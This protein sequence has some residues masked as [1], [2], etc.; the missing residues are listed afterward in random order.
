MVKRTPP[1]TGSGVKPHRPPDADPLVGRCFV[2]FGANGKIRH[3]GIIRARVE[4]SAYLIQYFD[5]IMGEPSTMKVVP[6][7]DLSC[8]INEPRVDAIELFEDAE[9]MS[10]WYEYGGGRGLLP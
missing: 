3:Q 5:W 6:L 2:T 9:H 4:P 1:K 10:Y 7:S 8:S